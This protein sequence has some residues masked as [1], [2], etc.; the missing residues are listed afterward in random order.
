[1]KNKLL[2]TFFTIAIAFS[3]V[4]SFSAIVS[5]KN[6]RNTEY[7]FYNRN[8]SGYTDSRLKEDKTKVY[9]NP[10]S[11]PALKYTVQRSTGSSNAPWHNR[12]ST[13]TIYSGTKASFTNKVREKGETFARLHLERT[14]A[15]Y[16]WTNGKWSPDSLKNYTVYN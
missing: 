14:S 4:L 1:M 13:H 15:A 8:S 3:S 16:A 10:I 2:S 9:I 6:Y 12:S 7:T 11:G 5:A